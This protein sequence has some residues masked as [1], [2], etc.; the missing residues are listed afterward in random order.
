MKRLITGI[1]FFLFVNLSNGQTSFQ[2]TFGSS[3]N[4]GSYS[5]I[6]TTDSN[7]VFTG[8]WQT[9]SG[10]T[11]SFLIKINAMG[12]T[13]WTKIKYVANPFPANSTYGQS[14]IQTSD[15]GFAVAG[16]INLMNPTANPNV[17][18]LRTNSSG[19][20]LWS[21]DYTPGYV[22]VAYSIKQTLDGGFIMAGYADSIASDSIQDFFLL[23]TNSLGDSLWSK[24][25]CWHSSDFSG[26]AHSVVQTNDGGYTLVGSQPQ[27][28]GLS[29][30]YFIKT[31]DNGNTLW[32]KKFGGINDDLGYWLDKTQDNGFIICGATMTTGEGG[33]DAYL[34]KTDEN[35]NLLWEK[36]YGGLDNEFANSVYPTSDGGYV[37]VGSTESYTTGGSYDVYL[38]KTDSQ[39][40]QI[41]HKTFG[42]I[43]A[44]YGYSVQ[45]TFDGGYIIAG[46][47]GA[48]IY[49]IKTDDM[50]N[51][52][53]IN[54]LNISSF[55]S[56][57]DIFPNPFSSITTIRAESYFQNAS[58]SV[59]NSFGQIVKQITNISGKTYDLSRENLDNGLYFVSLNQDNKVIETF[60]IV[61]TD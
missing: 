34:I 50:G 51:M 53:N 10:P 22:D 13:I 59:H 47:R 15:G 24:K 26:G 7:F 19:D 41:W 8:Y 48:E 45:Q 54:E 23:K 17:Y 35:G 56:K 20:S 29:D 9:G 32:T 18:L 11:Y 61:I 43:N 31:D 33:Y 44:D 25:Y 2:K 42:G 4:D 5:I 6:Q 27:L 58:I 12:D 39:G 30:V 36:T 52:T 1:T 46:I 16:N 37:I 14:V 40:N 60:K 38:I 55:F 3:G 21:K 57:V 49:I 28:T